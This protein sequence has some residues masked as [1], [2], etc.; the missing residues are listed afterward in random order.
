M[1]TTSQAT[2]RTLLG[3]GALA[4]VATIALVAS[5]VGGAVALSFTDTGGSPF[6]TEIDRITDAGCASGFPNGT[7]APRDN[8]KRQQFAFWLNNCGGRIAHTAP[9]GDFFFNNAPVRAAS[10]AITTGGA[11]GDG[12]TQF[13]DIRGTVAVGSEVLTFGEFCTSVFRCT[14]DVKLFVCVGTGPPGC[15]FGG[16]ALG[17]QTATW[18]NGGSAGGSNPNEFEVI[19]VETVVPVPTSTTVDYALVVDG[20]GLVEGQAVARGRQLTAEVVPFGHDGGNS[21]S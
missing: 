4:I 16:I 7:F 18:V 14:I 17:T 12:Q 3:K 20:N 9:V 19:T 15:G 10:G 11:T 5:M 6:A 13:V 1:E 21:L 2:A 8:V